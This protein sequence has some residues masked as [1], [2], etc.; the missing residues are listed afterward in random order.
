MYDSVV[1]HL[2]NAGI[3]DVRVVHTPSV[4]PY[5]NSRRPGSM[6]DDAAA[7]VAAAEAALSEGK[8]VVLLAHS[9]GG[10]PQSQALEKLLPGKRGDGKGGVKKVIYLASVVLQEGVSNFDLFG[11]NLPEFVKK[12]VSLLL[13]F[14]GL[15]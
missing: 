15:A 11:E 5:T 7:I 10:I 4:G 8:E 3:A 1:T 12:D 9:Y 14:R 13:F 6:S 2:N